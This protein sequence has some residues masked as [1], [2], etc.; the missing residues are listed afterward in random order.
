MSCLLFLLLII[1]FNNFSFVKHWSE[2]MQIA[3]RYYIH[4]FL[5]YIVKLWLFS[6]LGED[7]D[8]YYPKYVNILLWIVFVKI[9][10]LCY[11]HIAFFNLLS[12]FLCI[13]LSVPHMTLWNNSASI[14]FFLPFTH[15]CFFSYISEYVKISLWFLST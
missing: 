6:L 10:M 13:N 5:I 7:N 2:I 12:V 15:I 3:Q 4:G 1:T 14:I 9:V 8:R 11:I